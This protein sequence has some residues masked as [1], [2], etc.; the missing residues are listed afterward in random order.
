LFNSKSNKNAIIHG[1]YSDCVV[2]ENEK[3]EEFS[4]LLKAFCNEYNP[5]GA[6]EDAA[7]FDL[8]SLH[9]KK[10]RLEAGLQ[11]ALNLRRASRMADASGGGWDSIA[12]GARSAAKSQLTAAEI[13][14]DRIFKTM[15]RLVSKPDKTIDDSE[16]AIIGKITVL[17]QELNIVSKELIIPILQAA[18][19][20]KHD[21]IERAYNPDIMERELKIQAELDRRIDKALKRLMIIKEYKK[22][23]MVKS[24]DSK[25]LQIEALPAKPIGEKTDAEV[26]AGPLVIT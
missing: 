8:A 20:Q 18:E 13:L 4:D 16:A 3:P 5:Q 7:V 15:E 19:K 2:L 26:D 12:D 25:P 22:F 23:H 17:T 14:C 10:R 6:S 21:R 24:L 9:W 1:L 11:Q